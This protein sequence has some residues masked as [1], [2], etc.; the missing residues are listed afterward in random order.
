MA[1][2]LVD[3]RKAVDG[4]RTRPHA[5]VVDANGVLADL[6]AASL[7][8]YYGLHVAALA[9]SA[10]DGAAACSQHAP[11]LLVLNAEMAEAAWVPVVQSLAAANPSARVILLAGGPG[12]TRLRRSANLPPQVHAIVDLS[13]GMPALSS[14]V[15]QLLEEMDRAPA[16]LRVARI[17]SARELDV[18]RLIGRGMMNAAISERLGIRVQT[19]ETH[20]KSI[21]KKLRSTG[22]ELVR[23]AVLYV[24]LSG[25]FITRGEE[26]DQGRD[27]TPQGPVPRGV[28]DSRRRPH[29]LPG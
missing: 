28:H 18:F 2:G 16:S 27:P 17:L 4:W 14:Q 21:A 25:F 1:I 9:S 15:I 26:D 10:G 6:L 29:G 19:V 11:D 8:S 13:A 12:F 3:A 7:E 23:L 5:V 24:S 22:V 20:R